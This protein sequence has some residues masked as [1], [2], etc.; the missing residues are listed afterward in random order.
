LS[1]SKPTQ[2]LSHTN[3][4]TAPLI[5]D[6]V[7]DSEDES[8]TKDAP[9]GNPPYALKDKGVMDSGCSW[10]MTGNMSYLS[11]FEE[12]NGGYVAFGGNPKGGKISGKGKIKSGK[13]DFDDVYFVKELKFNLF[14][15]LQMCDKK[16]SVLFTDTEC[17]V[18]SPDFKLPDQ[19]Q[20]LL[21]VP[22]EN[23]MLHMDLFGPTFV[24]SLNKKSYFFVVTDDYNRFTWVFFL[25][26]KDETSPILKTFI[27]SLE[28]Q[29]S[30][31]VKVIKSD[32]G[33]EF[34]NSDLNQFY[35]M[36]G[37]KREFSVPRTPQQNDIVERKNKTLIEAARTM[38]ADS[39]LPVPFLAAAVNTACYV[40]NRVL[41][42]KP[43][44]KTPYELLH[45]RTPSIGFMR[46]FGCHVTILNTLDSLAGSESHPSRLNKENYVPWSS[47]LLRY[48]KSRPNGKLIHNSILNGPYVRRMIP[49]PGDAERDVNVNETF[50]EQTDDELSERELKQIE[51]DDQAIQTILLDLP[52][53]IYAAVDKKKAKFF[54]EWEMFTSNE[55]ESIESYYHRFLKLMNDLKRNKHFPEKIASNLKFLNNLLPEWSRY[56]TIVHQ[57]KDLHTADYTQLYDFLKYNQKEN[58]IGNGNLV[59]ARAEGNAAG[60]NGNQIRCYN[61]RGIGH[62]ARNCTARQRRRDA[63][64]LQTQLLITQK[65]EAGIQLQAEDKHRPRQEEQYTELLEPIPESHQ[66]PQN[67]NE[68]I[69]E[70]TGVE[71]GGETV[72]QYP[73]NFEETRA[74]YDSLYQNLATE[75]KK[76][77]SV[78]RKLKETNT[79]L[80]NEL[81]RYKNQE[82]CFEIS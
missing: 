67:D 81:A 71:Q 75:V 26:T 28:N 18:L 51:A 43:H 46:P 66:V 1:P 41:V 34:K 65:E 17:L 76:V 15:V 62:Y 22:R 68:V 36:K 49:E 4:P 12:L 35:G 32:N 2:D 61:C 31:K 48:A 82:R 52:E 58:Q 47:R 59:A 50:H 27:T 16:N 20:V 21:R 38:L 55:R 10:H 63:V 57:T 45:G 13:L 53:D 69:S 25:A 44:N 33:T 74:L 79:N 7:S 73:V 40:Q 29:L 60:Q 24:K 37:I 77:N 56:V 9:I 23:N 54:N 14:S 30:L 72:E 3:R 78:N 19:S 8:E 80:T 64:Y 5:E 70:V 6:W 11:E 42:T 39:L